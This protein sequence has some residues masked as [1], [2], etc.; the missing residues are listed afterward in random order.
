M[1]GQLQAERD[2]RKRDQREDKLRVR[3]G[4]V[5][6]SEKTTDHRRHERL[7]VQRARR[8]TTSKSRKSASWSLWSGTRSLRQRARWTST[9]KSGASATLPR[10]TSCCPQHVAAPHIDGD[11]HGM[12]DNDSY[13][14]AFSANAFLFHHV[15]S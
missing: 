14:Y 3:C 13:V 8:H 1:Q 5:Q 11:W 7:R 2:R 15:P 12:I 9:C 4:V 10:S 6:C